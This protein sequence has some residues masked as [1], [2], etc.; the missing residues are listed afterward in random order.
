MSSLTLRNDSVRLMISDGDVWF[1]DFRQMMGESFDTEKVAA[2]SI[3]DVFKHIASL[4]V[5]YM[6]HHPTMKSVSMRLTRPGRRFFVRVS[7]NE[8]GLKED[9]VSRRQVVKTALNLGLLQCPADTPLFTYMQTSHLTLPGGELGETL[10]FPGYTFEHEHCTKMWG[11]HTPL[12]FT[13]IVWFEDERVHP[14]WKKWAF[15]IPANKIG[16]K[17]FSWQKNRYKPF[18]QN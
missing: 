5:A 8:L 13:N 7:G 6:T 4:G 3:E 2:K 14:S 12:D 15:E 16:L 17:R 9:N 1:V 10:Y 11:L 18:S